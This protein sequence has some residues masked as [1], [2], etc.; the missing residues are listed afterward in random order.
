M[1]IDRYEIIHGYKIASG[2]FTTSRFYSLAYNEKC[3]TRFDARVEQDKFDH[4]EVADS[5]AE[6]TLTLDRSWP[7]TFAVVGLLTGIGGLIGYQFKKN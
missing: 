5:F 1:S 7:R 3:V 2:T 4:I 6:Q